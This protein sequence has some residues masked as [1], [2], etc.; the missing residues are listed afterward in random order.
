MIDDILSLAQ[1]N[2]VAAFDF[3][4]ARKVL[5]R[6]KQKSGQKGKMLVE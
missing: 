1:P 4:L 3:P 6:A 2:L 5:E